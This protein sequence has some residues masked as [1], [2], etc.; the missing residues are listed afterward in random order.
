MRK[1]LIFV[2]STLLFASI[3][4]IAIVWTP[5][6]SKS[7]LNQTGNSVNAVKELPPQV[8]YNMMFHHVVWTQKQASELEKQGKDG[9]I[10][11]NRYKNYAKL[12]DVESNLLN[13]VASEITNQV[14]EIE[15]QAKP[16]IE[17][18]RA[19]RKMKQEFSAPPSLSPQLAA[20]EKERTAAIIAGVDRLKNA[21]GAQRFI[22]F[23]TVIRE[24]IGKNITQVTQDL[25]YRPE[26]LNHKEPL[27]FDKAKGRIK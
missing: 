6:R 7:K 2:G 18:A 16:L 22:D 14:K 11:R 4:I 19:E 15:A 24:Q 25:Q 27:Y 12:T 17:A 20:L 1:P 26:F 5:A 21:Y 9:S 8:I 23:E 10:F 3:L 13:Q